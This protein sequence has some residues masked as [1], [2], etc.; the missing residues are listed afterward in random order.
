VLSFVVSWVFAAIALVVA[1]KLFARVRLD[2]DFGTALFVAAVYGVLQ[3]LF[4]WLFFV[5]L[6]FATLGIGFIFYLT[7]MIVSTAIVIKMTA[8]LSRRFRVDGFLPAIGTAILMTVAA[9]IAR[10]VV[11]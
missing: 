2:G 10:R 1:D 5:V 3:F 7:T 8:G 4:G 11:A 6:G 9:E